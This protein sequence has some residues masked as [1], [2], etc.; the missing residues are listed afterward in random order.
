M[1]SLS[2]EVNPLLEKWSGKEDRLFIE[3]MSKR[4]FVTE[5]AFDVIKLSIFDKVYGR[6]ESELE[7][8]IETLQYKLDQDPS[9]EY[10]IEELGKLKYE[11]NR[12]FEEL[13]EY[14][15]EAKYPFDPK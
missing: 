15:C 14:Y 6:K 5:E 9:N 1:S 4:I 2:N 11:L 8:E 7:S 12:S 3:I 13:D 10:L